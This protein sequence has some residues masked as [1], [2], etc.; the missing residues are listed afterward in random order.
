MFVEVGPLK[1]KRK[2]MWDRV[3]FLQNRQL[4]ELL[5]LINTHD[6]DG[7]PIGRGNIPGN[8]SSGIV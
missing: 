1:V 2:Y 5:L 6:G 4:C 3:E 7:Q 8:T